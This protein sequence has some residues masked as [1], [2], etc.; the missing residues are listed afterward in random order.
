D[1]YFTAN[2]GPNKLYLN[3]GELKFQD[4]SQKSVAIGRAGPWKTGVNMV[5]INGDSKL[6]IYL[7]YSGALP[8]P[9]RMNQL[10]IN[11][12]NDENG[13]PKFEDQAEKY[14]I[15]SPAFSNQS[16][17]FD[18]DRDGDL[19]MLLL[20]HNPKSL[21]VLTEA[22]TQE[23][24]RIPDPLRGLR[25][26]ENTGTTFKDV[27]E[28]KG[29]NGSALSYGLGLGISDLNQD[30]WPDFYV[31]NDYTV[32]DYLY[33]NQKGKKFVNTLNTSLGHNSHFSM[34]NDLADINNDGL[35]DIFTLDML[36]EDNYRQKLLLAPDNYSKFDLNIRSG[37]HY[38]YMR[39]MLQL[40]NGDDTYSEIGQIE[41]I[42][43]TDWS[44]SA[45]FSDFDNDGWKDLFISNGYK[46]DY[47]NLDFIKYMEDFI[48]EKGRMKRQDVMELIKN[49]PASN[50]TNY[51]FSNQSGKGFENKV[52][53]WGM[54]RPSNSNGAVF[55]DLDNDGD[56]DVVIN[57]VNQNAHIYRNNSRQQSNSH[58]LQVEL[59]GEGKNT[60]GIGA[61]VEVF[62]AGTWQSLEQYPARGYL[63]SVSPILH[64]GLGSSKQIDSLRITWPGGEQGTQQ[65]IAADQRLILEENKAKKVQAKSSSSQSIFHQKR[66]PISFRDQKL[67]YR[68]FDRQLLLP[69][70]LSHEGPSMAKGDVN[71]D[72]K[73]DL[74]M[75][76]GQNQ[77]S[78]LFLNLGE[79]RF[80][81]NLSS[82]FSKDLIYVDD[83]SLFVDVDKDG[84]LDLYIASG[85]YHTLAA[86]DQALQDRLY[87]ND[88]KGKFSRAKDALPAILSSAGAL[89]AGDLNSDG[90]ID[91]FIG[92][93]A[94]PGAY[95]STPQSYALIN[96]GKGKFSNQI[97]ELLPDLEYAGMITHAQFADLSGD[98][99]EEL[100]I[101][102]EWMPI[103]V[104][105]QSP[106]GWKEVSESYFDTSYKAWWNTLKIVDINGD[107]KLDIIAGNMGT[108]TQFQVSPEEPAQ[109]YYS[110]FDKN[111]SIDPIFCYYIQGES[112]PYV[113]RD[114][115]LG[116]LAKFRA[117]YTNFTS[118]ANHKIPNIFTPD[119]LKEAQILEANHMK[120][121]LFIQG[122]DG[123]FS[124][125][126][127]PREAQYSPIFSIEVMDINRDGKE[128][129][130][131]FGNNSFAKLRLGKFDANYGQA[132]LGDG[133]GGFKYLPQ[134]Q[135][136]FS[137]KGDIRSSEIIENGIFLG[138]NSGP[139]W[140]GR[141]VGGGGVVNLWVLVAR[142][143]RQLRSRGL[144]MRAVV[145][146]ATWRCGWGWGCRRA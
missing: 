8:D 30:G 28:Q 14:G 3:K 107:N 143:A 2:M 128:D 26:F 58:Y 53:A 101:A 144:V 48:E 122:A 138:Q 12:G 129:L 52:K 29:I 78:R 4:I 88:R 79:G 18:Y 92:G 105:G 141:G 145:E 20:N 86:D 81:E 21:P 10:F 93:R 17:F 34:G 104:Y 39:N 123:K 96:D 41:G 115:L 25:F 23:S 87:L 119:E 113:T 97:S 139:L 22:Q 69:M 100:I 142:T 120:T 118:Y 59:K 38:Q 11:L 126:E 83:E 64:I 65:N 132:Y 54:N 108:N 15:N 55:S 114:E 31:S 37:F 89:A 16:Y 49:M 103:I 110:D 102:G 47:T 57:N 73:E 91:F 42:S 131:L 27:T 70:E 85:G 111:G 45:L 43:N 76:A 33:I 133:K 60:A 136:G 75:G 50:V 56:M 24:L 80:K 19:D 130:L 98:G 71:G 40:N 135:S 36:P 67:P 62:H 90:H 66:S 68:D 84:D 7:C 77:R 125:Q 95:P 13:I 99:K 32:P 146:E 72:G 106:E 127:L 140:G 5:D 9:K 116:Q 35:M 124:Y 94:V 44:W 63:S 82:D 109:L 51:I 121:S 61:K 112:Y 134:Y 117:K 137:I 1:L 74:F 6:D 46:R